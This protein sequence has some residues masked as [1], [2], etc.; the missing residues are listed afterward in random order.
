ME[1]QTKVELIA[2]ITKL[3]KEPPTIRQYPLTLEIRQGHKLLRVQTG[4]YANI[5]VSRSHVTRSFADIAFAV[6]HFLD[7]IISPSHVRG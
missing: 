1:P 7:P 4:D 3:M 6:D 5:T 2:L